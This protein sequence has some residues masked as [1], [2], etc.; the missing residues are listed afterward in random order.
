MRVLSSYHGVLG[1]EGRFAGHHV[2][3]SGD[4]ADLDGEGDA[5]GDT[6]VRRSGGEVNRGCGLV[7]GT[8]VA[9]WEIARVCLL[10]LVGRLLGG[11]IWGVVGIVAFGVV[12]GG[13]VKGGRDFWVRGVSGMFGRCCRVEKQNRMYGVAP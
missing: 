2:A 3:E 8:Y 9:F 6:A 4:S 13:P 12:G 5:L 7:W 10:G 1:L 11:I